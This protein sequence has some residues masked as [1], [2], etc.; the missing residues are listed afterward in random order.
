M[1]DEQKVVRDENGQEFDAIVRDGE[2][3]RILGP[4]SAAPTKTAPAVAAPTKDIAQMSTPTSLDSHPILKRILKAAL[5]IYGAASEAED[6]VKNTMSD[7]QQAP[8]RTVGQNVGSIVGGVAG[9]RVAGSGGAVAG[10]GIGRTLGGITGQ[11]ISPSEDVDV[12]DNVK[13]G[14]IDA[15][16]G[17]AV[18]V[19]G[20]RV[21]GLLSNEKN[22]RQHL[23]NDIMGFFGSK[24]SL[25]PEQ[26]AA[27]RPDTILTRGQVTGSQALED[28]L[29]PNQKT[30]IARQQQAQNMG[31]VPNKVTTLGPQ[32]AENIPRI[33]ND[34]ETGMRGATVALNQN[35]G[36]RATEA[37][38]NKQVLDIAPERTINTT[39]QV[40]SSILGP[41]GQPVMS[42]QVSQQKIKGPIVLLETGKIVKD[43]TD[44]IAK[45]LE[46][47]EDPGVKTRFKSLISRLQPLEGQGVAG[48]E[49]IRA[50][51]SDL[52]DML[53]NA[54]RWQLTK[55]EAG[56][57]K[58]AKSLD[59]DL[60][61]SVSTWTKPK[62]YAGPSAE[63]LLNRA[64]AV[65]TTRFNRFN[66]YTNKNIEKAVGDPGTK[67]FTRNAFP[68]ETYKNAFENVDTAKQMVSTTGR[69]PTAQAFVNDLEGKFFKHDKGVVEG[70][71]AL[72][73]LRNPETAEMMKEFTNKEQRQGLM[74]FFR[75]AQIMDPRGKSSVGSMALRFAEG[76]AILG[77]SE[78]AARGNF[79]KAFMGKAAAKLSILIGGK[80]FARDVLL[81]PTQARI[82][83]GLISKPQATPMEVRHIL[84]AIG[85]TRIIL[86]TGDG[87]KFNFDKAT[88]KL[89]P[90]SEDS[91]Q[92]E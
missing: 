16:I 64:N 25:T 66:D 49:E 17:G 91:G 71:A 8:G 26:T 7:V 58:L 76:N 15:L 45:Q 31:T 86:Q 9:G 74:N 47:I 21:S 83:A 69:L 88:K 55:A 28:L 51:K 72:D 92:K 12:G 10:S 90:L 39:T 27:I 18:K 36:L 65:T 67:P 29:A 54:K 78:E 46:I 85:G 35:K 24:S 84:G 30:I 59:E 56:L 6:L 73:Y 44:A 50:I 80:K 11:A 14:L 61:F 41:N 4:R 22:E 52:Y 82:A 53:G 40:P 38:L 13:A 23:A 42:N 77:V 5:P 1:A 68:S 20:P 48:F 81:N 2:V 34:A 63:D 37:R 3:L 57:S 62:G 32:P 87:K 43:Q 19:A 75:R 79:G 60:K 89:T 33:G 70:G